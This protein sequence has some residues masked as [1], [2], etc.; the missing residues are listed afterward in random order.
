[1]PAAGVLAGDDVVP[2]HDPPH[3]ESTEG[4]HRN[5]SGTPPTKTPASSVIAT[6]NRKGVD[7]FEVMKLS[8]AKQAGRRMTVHRPL[9]GLSPDAEPSCRRALL[10]RGLQQLALREIRKRAGLGDKL[11]IASHLHDL[12]ANQHDDPVRIA[13]RAQPMR[14]HHP[15][16]GEPLE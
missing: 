10:P 11:P 8:S 12:A 2:A 5:R 16:D 1:M 6:P 9:R 3:Q 7:H 14:D 13:D 4:E 15:R